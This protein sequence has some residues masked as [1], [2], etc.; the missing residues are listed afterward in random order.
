VARTSKAERRPADVLRDV[1][2]DVERGHLGHE[3]SC[4]V[5]L[6]GAESDPIGPGRMAHDHLPG[7]LA[8]GGAGRLRHRRRDDEHVAIFHQR[9]AYE[10]E[11]GLLAPSLAAE[12]RLGIRVET[13]VAWLRFSP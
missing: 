2:C 13:W 10:A 11:L 4:V 12:P 3:G 8:P 9:V 5:A 7:R 1:R 6:V